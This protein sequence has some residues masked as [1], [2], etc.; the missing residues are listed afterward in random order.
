M[1]FDEK[2][3]LSFSATFASFLASFASKK[4]SGVAEQHTC[5]SREGM[6]PCWNPAC[7][8][9]TSESYCDTWITSRT[10]G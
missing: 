4:D 2:L 8:G 1:E 9:M 6:P 10:T 3:R 5:H 7:A